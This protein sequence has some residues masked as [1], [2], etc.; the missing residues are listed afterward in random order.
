MRASSDRPATPHHAAAFARVALLVAVIAVP[1][2]TWAQDLPFRHFTPKS[3]RLPLPSSDVNQVIQDG[4]G[5]VWMAVY[6]SGVLRYD[7]VRTVLFTVDDGLRDLNVWQIAQDGGGR[8]WVG[9]DAGLVASERPLSDYAPGERPRFTGAIGGV[10]FPAEAVREHRLVADPEGGV[11]MAGASD[12][13]HVSVSDEVAID[14]IRVGVEGGIQAIALGQER[15]LWVAGSQGGLWVCPGGRSPA[16]AMATLDGIVNVLLPQPDGTLFVGTRSGDVVRLLPSSDPAAPNPL[17]VVPVVTG[18]GALVVDLSTPRPDELWVGTEGAGLLRVLRAP[19]GGNPFI[20]PLAGLLSSTVH[21]VMQDREGNTWIAQTGGVSR[22]SHNFDAFSGYRSTGSEFAPPSLPEPYVLAVLDGGDSACRFAGTLSQ[23]LVCIDPTGRFFTVTSLDGLPSDRVNAL[24]RTGDGT[25]WIGTHAGPAALVPAGRRL[26]G[27]VRK[28]EALLGGQALTVTTFPDFSGSVISATVLDLGSEP[29][30]ETVWLSSFRS[31]VV[32]VGDRFVLLGADVGLPSTLFRAVARDA[33]GRIWVGTSDS[34]L[35]RSREAVT[36][37][38]L[39]SPDRSAAGLRFEPAAS[40]SSGITGEIESLIA[41]GGILY[42]GTPTGL[43]ALNA[44]DSRIVARID[45]SSGMP[46]PN[47]T[48]M[49]L[50]PASGSI[51]VGT[52][53]GLVEVRTDS[54]SVVRVLTKTDGLPS[55]EVCFYGSVRIQPDGSVQFGTCDGLGIYRPDR[56]R[57]N[58]VAPTPAV[59]S[60]TYLENGWGTNSLE[61]EF[62]ALSFANELKT[63]FRTRLTGYDEEWSEP[64]ETAALRYTNL[65]AFLFSRTYRFE[66]SAAN[67]SGTWS[68]EPFVL[69][70]RVAPAWYLRWWAMLV[71]LGLLG[72]AVVAYVRIKTRQAQEQLE[73]ERAINEQLRQVDR[74]KDEFL[75]NTSHELRTPLNGIIGI[76]ESLLDGVAGDVTDMMRTNLA[77]VVASGRRLASLVN[78]ILDFSKMAE[79]DVTLQQRAVSVRVL[80]DIVLRIS[81][82]LLGGK[83]VT[84]RND[85]SRDIPAVLADESRLQQILHNLIGNAIKFT[86]QGEVRVFAEHRGEFVAISVADTGIGIPADKRDAVFKS[87]EQVDASTAREYGGTGLG[88]SITKRLV[89]LH[90]GTIDFQST[91]GVGSVFTFT[92]PA[93]SDEPETETATSVLSRLREEPSNAMEP[94]IPSGDGAAPMAGGMAHILVVDDEPVNQQVLANHLAFSN[95]RLSQALNGQQAL[96]L[97]ASDTKFDLVLL[98]IMMPRMSGY[99]VCAVIRQRYLPSELPVIMVTAKNQ[100]SDLVT[101][102]ASGAND[103]IAKPFSK[104]ELL[105]RIKTHLNLGNINASYGR[106][107]P[108][109]FFHYLEKESILDVQL[110]DNVEKEMSIFVSDIRSFTT[111]SEGMTPS[112]NFRFVNDYMAVAGPIIRDFRG[113]IDRYTGDSIMG[114]FAESPDDAVDAAVETLIRVR[115]LNRKFE[116]D[117]IPEVRIGVGVHTGTLRLGIVGERERLQGDIFSDAVNLANR[118]E[119]LCKKY[120]AS[121]I[122]SGDTLSRLK[123]P[124]RFRT[125]LIGHVQVAGKNR[126]VEVHEIYDGDPEPVIARRDA[127]LADFRAGCAAFYAA[128][129]AGA[130][131]AF[132]AVVDADPDDRPAA[133]YLRRIEDLQRNGIPEG[134]TGVDSLDSK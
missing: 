86:H 106:F 41:A 49:D 134:W 32:R 33:D 132:Q 128:D 53:A 47:A 48:S 13:L 105:A 7:G 67:D 6:S 19:G 91:V 44:S 100:V 81:E 14:T 2:V 103:Y 111:I 122:V 43:A 73:K 61:V 59:T 98:D 29:D 62:A 116:A 20:V 87:F 113:F 37:Q 22:L 124:S 127:G 131:E 45:E 23:G 83:D 54:L 17:A 77:T 96:D 60:F 1:T 76:V 9:S 71:W 50:S 119:G 36:A 99:E 63:R 18:L 79:H 93:T 35:F 85:I 126:A 28:R 42:V 27:G 125:R 130:R 82:P 30:G 3:E 107:L 4:Q 75:A 94:T 109:E 108:R 70:V 102:F 34:G 89:E 16:R 52:N 65:P 101:G 90:G 46:A 31:I 24:A 114:L 88:L 40:D 68:T 64:S 78:D 80:T 66:V 84:L 92:L 117:G 72:S 121:I 133:L 56:D 115:D 10:E 38:Q 110:G 21:Q 104:D 74:M 55:D 12:V 5:F 15:D 120:G 97:L 11:F 129:L 39:L 58:A 51:W 26:Q 112:E 8:L 118:I 123:D 95:F 57:P 25:I 69:P